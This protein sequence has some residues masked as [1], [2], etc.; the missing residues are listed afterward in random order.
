M[1]IHRMS[2]VAI[3]AACVLVGVPARGQSL[4]DLAKRTQEQKDKATGDAAAKTADAGDTDKKN[5]KNEKKVYTDQDL[6]TLQPIVGGTAA[7]PDPAVPAGGT[8]GKPP[9]ATKDAPKDAGKGEAYWR[10]RWMPMAEKI[11]KGEEHAAATRKRIDELTFQLRSLG[12]LA[13]ERGDMLA[14]RQRAIALEKGLIE[15]VA[16]DKAALTAIQEEGR[17]AGALPGWFR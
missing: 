8:N 6:K 4:G 7:T 3:G 16:A 17:R 2:L 12:A 14:E 11:A 9:D 1:A 10:G 15:Q 13:T 5:G